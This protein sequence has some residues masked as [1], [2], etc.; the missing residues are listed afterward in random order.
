MLSMLSPVAIVLAAGKG[1]RMKSDLPKVL[2]PVC[3]RPMVEYVLEALQKVG[4]RRVVVVVGYR[5]E[6]VR[7]ALTNWQAGGTLTPTLSQ[8]ERENLAL[9]FV[10][11]SPQLGTGHAVMVCRPAL[12]NHAGQILILT[13]DS[14][15]V[16]PASLQA[17]FTEFERTRPACLMGTAIKQNPA[18]LGR[19]VRD[20]AGNFLMIVEEKDASPEQLATREVNMSYYLFDS[21]QLWHALDQVRNDN[22][23]GEYYITDCP[24]IL[25]QEGKDVRALCALDPCETLSVNTV[26]ELGQVEK[27]LI[28]KRMSESEKRN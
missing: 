2:F 10:E 28:E 5:G 19:V 11:Q 14:P 23:Q 9:E 7:K 22:K 15:L 26:D 20:A 16:Q 25:K 17:M 8:R 12:A 3:G 1:T 21:R 13:G 24:G 4:V 18:G 6:L 27:E